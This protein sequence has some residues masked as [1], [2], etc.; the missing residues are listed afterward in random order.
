MVIITDLLSIFM[1][2]ARSNQSKICFYHSQNQVIPGDRR[3][4]RDKGVYEF[5]PLLLQLV[6][7]WGG[8]D[9]QE[10]MGLLAIPS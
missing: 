9:T 2:L 3:L 7:G 6:F 4:L 8:V 10:R 5:A 1:C